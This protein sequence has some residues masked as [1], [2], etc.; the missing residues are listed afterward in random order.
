MKMVSHYYYLRCYSNCYLK[1]VTN[2]DSC[3][4]DFTNR[5][6]ID[7]VTNDYLLK[8]RDVSL[9]TCDQWQHQRKNHDGQYVRFKLNTLF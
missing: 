2:L 1:K 7:K 6:G 5:T 4:L 9:H 8:L 3:I